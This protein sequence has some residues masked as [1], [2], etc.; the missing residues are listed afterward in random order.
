MTGELSK[1]G[2]R[3][4]E[5]YGRDVRAGLGRREIPGVFVEETSKGFIAAL[6]EEVGFAN[7]LVGQGSVEG[8]GGR[9]QQQGCG[10]N[11]EAGPEGRGHADTS[12]LIRRVRM[13]AQFRG[14]LKGIVALIRVSRCWCLA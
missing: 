8:E 4:E 14:W 2:E 7:G 10:E 12:T 11:R 3:R 9:R 6:A 13:V 1:N 5:S